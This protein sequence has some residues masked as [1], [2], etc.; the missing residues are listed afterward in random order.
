MIY[1]KLFI[2]VLVL[3]SIAFAGMAVRMFFIKKGTFVN[4]HIEGNP[5]MRKLGIHCAQHEESTCAAGSENEG[6]ASCVHSFTG[7]LN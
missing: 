6:C 7:S 1:L 5:A 2:I 4:T 3:L